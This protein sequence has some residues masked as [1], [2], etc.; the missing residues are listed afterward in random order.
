M[1]VAALPAYNEEV[2]IGSVVLKT[3]KH[4][5]KVI[6]VDDASSDATGEIARL[7]GAFV[8]RH[9]KN[10]G[11]GGALKTCFEEAR[12]LDANAMVILDADGQ[13]DP[14]DIPVILEPIISSKADIV[15]GSM[16]IRK[17]QNKIPKYRKALLKSKIAIKYNLYRI[18]F[19]IG[20]RLKM[21]CRKSDQS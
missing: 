4:V 19:I 6:V 18:V 8:I 1:I 3:L 10:E 9:E 20:K 21:A 5:D 17:N 13:H 12:K 15:I 2:K 14:R 11:Y 7:A 16:F